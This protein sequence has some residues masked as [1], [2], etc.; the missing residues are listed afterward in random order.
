MPFECIDVTNWIKLNEPAK[1]SRN[2][3]W[4]AKPDTKVLEMFLFKESHRRHPVEFWSEV[5]THHIGKLAGVPTPETFCARMGDTYGALIGFFLKMKDG[6]VMES[7]DHGG[8]LILAK[9]P[10]FDRTKGERHNIFFV[11]RIFLE[12]KRP[13]LFRD[14]LGTLVFDALIGNT[15]RHQDNWG[16]ILEKKRIVRLTPAFDNSDSLG[17]EIVEEKISNFLKDDGTRLKRYIED[18]KPHVRWS[19]DGQNLEWINHFEFLKRLSH[20][21]PEVIK[22]VKLQTKFRDGD[23]DGILTPLAGVKVDSPQYALSP[24]RIQ[25]IKKIICFRRDILK[26]LFEA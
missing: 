21:W 24:E 8:D 6:Q 22:Y 12:S 20:K 5:I 14:F 1:G 18:G 2:K 26:Q 19:V 3:I 17:R 11:E 9:Y 10:D 4:V 25:F 23:I 16:F 13:D 7:L 15:D